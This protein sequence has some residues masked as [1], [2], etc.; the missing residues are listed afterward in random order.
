MNRMPNTDVV[1]PKDTSSL[2]IPEVSSHS[3]PLFDLKK[4]GAGEKLGKLK[5]QNRSEMISILFLVHNEA[6]VIEKTIREFY[7]EIGTKI[8]LEIVVIEDGSIDGSKKILH[9]LSAS[10]PMKLIMAEKRRGYWEAAKAG[11]KHVN[12]KLV[13]ITDSDGQ[14]VASDFW[15]LYGKRDFYD[16]VVGWKKTRADP[17][18][19]A[20]LAKT[21]HFLVRVLF[22]FPLHDPNTAYRLMKKEVLTKVCGETRFLKYSFWTEF[23]VRSFKRG[24]KLVEVPISHKRRSNGTTRIYNLGLFPDM[25]VSQL[26]G[27]FRL[28]RELRKK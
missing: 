6:E 24:F 28:W 3:K 14:F 11:L 10:L 5:Q 4:V 15:K 16:M 12:S 17:P 22:G 19:R 26:T 7:S 8:A 1:T 9:D 25:F 21:F 13:F 18:H 23:T 2:R 20:I 27:L